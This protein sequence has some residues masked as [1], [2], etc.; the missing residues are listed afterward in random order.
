MPNKK[1]SKRELIDTGRD[2]R[3]VRRDE[4]GRLNESVEVDRSLAQDVRKHAKTVAKPG[5]GDRGDQ[6]NAK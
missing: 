3:F 2:K 6:K 4:K 5:Q 1:A